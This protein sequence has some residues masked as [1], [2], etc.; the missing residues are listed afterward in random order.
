MTPINARSPEVSVAVRRGQEIE[1]PAVSSPSA[2]SSTVAF[3]NDPSGNQ[4]SACV[5]GDESISLSIVTP[6]AATLTILNDAASA[7]IR[8]VW[9]QPGTFN[10]QCLD[11]VASSS[12][13]QDNKPTFEVAIVPGYNRNMAVATSEETSGGLHSRGGE[14]WCVLMD[15]DTG[16]ELAKREASDESK[17]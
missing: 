10:Q 6:P 3:V 9:F 16:R 1:I 5:D 17:M 2:V 8:R 14:G 11:Y 12:S 4:D 13:S 15:G 7:G